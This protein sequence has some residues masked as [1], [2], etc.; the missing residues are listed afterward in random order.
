MYSRIT[1][2]LT[3]E[4]DDRDLEIRSGVSAGNGGTIVASGDTAATRRALPSGWWLFLQRDVPEY[5]DTGVRS[6]TLTAGTYWLAVAPDSTGFFDQSFIETTS[7]ANAVST[8]GNN[9]DMSFITTNF[10]TS[11]PFASTRPRGRS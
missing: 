3:P 10:P 6:S 1:R 2:W 5:P 9:H 11:G 7:G 8:P 4:R